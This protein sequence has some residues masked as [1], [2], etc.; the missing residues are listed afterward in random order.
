M[1]SCNPYSTNFEAPHLL[2]WAF[3]SSP[4][5]SNFRTNGETQIP[6]SDTDRQRTM[7]RINQGQ[8]LMMQVEMEME[9]TGRMDKEG[10]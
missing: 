2:F 6:V 4:V 7:L 10:C 8:E 1:M 3:G 9:M 5:L